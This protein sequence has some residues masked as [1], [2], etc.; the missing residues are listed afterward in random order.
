MGEA[1]SSRRTDDVVPEGRPASP[2]TS[3]VVPNGGEVGDFGRR[4]KPGGATSYLRGQRQAGA[5]AH[6]LGVMDDARRPHVSLTIE[7]ETPPWYYMSAVM[8][9]GAWRF[10]PVLGLQRQILVSRVTPK[11][12]GELD[13]SMAAPRTGRARATSVRSLRAASK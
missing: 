11:S 9:L 3:N 13:A 10:L 7:G 5:R 1:G 2:T 4:G 6:C 12:V 8:R